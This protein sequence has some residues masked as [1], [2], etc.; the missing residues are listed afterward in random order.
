MLK[1]IQTL[2]GRM[3]KTRTS[4]VPSFWPDDSY[5]H[6]QLFSQEIPPIDGA[7]PCP[8]TVYESSTPGL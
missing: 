4:D 1:T 3:T 8:H 7:M 5:L 6:L 2:T